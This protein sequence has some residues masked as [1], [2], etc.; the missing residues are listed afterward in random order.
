MSANTV[1]LAN[2]TINAQNLANLYPNSPE[3]V[4][5]ACWADDLKSMH[6]YLEVNMHYINLP[7]IAPGYTGQIPTVDATNAPWAIGEANGTVSS[8]QANDLDKA[9][10]LRFIIH[11]VGDIHQPLHSV[12][13]FSSQFPGGDQGGNLWKINDPKYHMPQ[14]HELWDSGIGVWSNDPTRP[15]NTSAFNMLDSIADEVIK[16]FPHTD[17][18]IVPLIKETKTMQWANE[19]FAIAQSF[20]YT[21]PQ[22]P[23]PIPDGY[24]TPAQT[25]CRR[26][27]ALGGYRL[28]LL[29]E[30]IFS[31]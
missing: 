1:K 9:R 4:S 26:Q 23:S 19:S 8:K 30:T 2:A 21:A 13:Y 7:V 17:P 12:N 24:Y 15:L 10:M 3:F 18:A 14:L 20:V 25:T 22:A 31:Q 11:F 5:A 6:E 29:I 27:V 28:A 16:E